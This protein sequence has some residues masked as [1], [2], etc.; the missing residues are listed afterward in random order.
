[1]KGTITR[2]LAMMVKSKRGSEA[3][4]AIVAG[5]NPGD[6]L[7]MLELVSSDVDDGL[8]E[9]LLAETCREMRMTQQEAYDAFGEYWCCEYAPQV[10]RSVMNRFKSAEEMILALDHVHVAVTASMERAHPPRFDYRRKD[11]KTL[12]VDY[13]SSRKMLGLYV[14]LVRGVGKYFRQPLKVVVVGSNQVE[15]TFS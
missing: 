2:C 5:A 10:Y 3:W 8:V 6:D 14:G 7:P 1:M 15:I 9:R 11:A 4:R 13:K 12:V